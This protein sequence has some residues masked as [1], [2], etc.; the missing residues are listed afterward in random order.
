MTNRTADIKWGIEATKNILSETISDYTYNL[1]NF[2]NHVPGN[3]ELRAYK[4][5]VTRIKKVDTILADD[6]G[7]DLTK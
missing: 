3:Q 5:E 7:L 6:T 4:D 1:E 2:L